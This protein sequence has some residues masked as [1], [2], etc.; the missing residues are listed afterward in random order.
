[1]TSE[2]EH[3]IAGQPWTAGSHALLPA[4]A[5]AT[6]SAAAGA[7]AAAAAA[8]AASAAVSA[9]QARIEE[10]LD[11]KAD[12]EYEIDVVERKVELLREEVRVLLWP[13]SVQLL[14][15]A[16]CAVLQAWITVR[17]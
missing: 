1:M 11:D 4:D 2:V 6:T 3:D 13:A 9:A 7:D 14:L 10:L 17:C 5:S 15:V 8:T 16:C 12:L